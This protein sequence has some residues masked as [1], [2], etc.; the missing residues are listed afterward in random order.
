MSPTA[1]TAAIRIR[2]YIRKHG[3][4]LVHSY[5]PTAVFVAPIARALGVPA[6]LSSTLGYRNLHS[7]RT[8]RQLRWID[9]IVDTVVVNCEA[10][11]QH[12]IHDERFPDERIMLCYNGV[13]T[14]L[15]TPRRRRCPLRSGMLPSLSGPCAFCVRRKP[16]VC[17]KKRLPKSA[18]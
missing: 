12:M 6:V 17:C 5:D 14:N 15:S 3:I 1:L 9:K 11:R 13:N 16:S 8:R 10:M 2:R 7:H 4:R 18:I